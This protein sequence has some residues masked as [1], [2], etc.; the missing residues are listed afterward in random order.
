M[1]TETRLDGAERL[2]QLPVLDQ[3]RLVIAQNLSAVQAVEEAAPA[4]AQAVDGIAD[5][6]SHGGRL[7]YTGAGTSGRLGVMDAAEIWPTFGVDDQVIAVVAG[8]R[9]ALDTAQETVEDDPG[10]AGADLDDIGIGPEDA[11]VAVS[12]SGRTPYGLGAL[13]H[14]HLRGALGVAVVNNRDSALAAAA[15]VAIVVSTGPEVVTGSTRM[16]AGTAQKVV[17]NILSTLVMVARGRTYGDLMVDMVATNAKLQHRARRIVA[18][19]TGA[20]DSL[21]IKMLTAAGGE[22]KTAIVMIL[23]AVDAD[24]A[25]QL[26]SDGEGHVRRALTAAG[27]SSTETPAPPGQR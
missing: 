7:I 4:I 27:V 19:A 24:A 25:R 12:A 11:V 9:Q 13:A 18:Q 14:S 16:K 26:L 17:L 10:Q 3:V 15:D 23:A 8:G 21:A 1:D 22:V 2:D 5:R 20:D 6:M